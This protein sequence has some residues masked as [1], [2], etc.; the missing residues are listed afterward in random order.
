MKEKQY[1]NKKVLKQQNC[2]SSDSLISWLFY[3]TQNLTKLNNFNRIA[4]P[5]MH[6]QEN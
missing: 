4:T 3:K 2:T 6:N 5:N 1:Q